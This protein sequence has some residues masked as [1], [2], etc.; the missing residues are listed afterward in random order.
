MQIQHPRSGLNRHVVLTAEALHQ[1]DS[2]ALRSAA[3]AWHDKLAS[4]PE[5]L[6]VVNI[7]G[8]ISSRRYGADLAKRLT[9]YYKMFYGAMGPLL[10]KQILAEEGSEEEPFKEH[11]G[12]FPAIG[13]RI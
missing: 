2:T 12:R 7:G 6:L 3:S 5:L 1:A 10:L 13:Q 8:P 4:L 11:C 9:F